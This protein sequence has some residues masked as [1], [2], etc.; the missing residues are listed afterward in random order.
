MNNYNT[1]SVCYQI[2][3]FKL[4]ALPADCFRPADIS[5]N[6]LFR[7]LYKPICINNKK[8]TWSTKWRTS[9][10]SVCGVNF[11]QY[12][13]CNNGWCDGKQRCLACCA[14]YGGRLS[15][16]GQPYQLEFRM[17]GDGQLV[18]SCWFWKHHLNNTCWEWYSGRIR[19]SWKGDQFHLF[20]KEKKGGWIIK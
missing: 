17:L 12:M 13:C 18:H 2:L 4:N 5:C 20:L 6:R 8:H 19:V 7:Q 14:A 3:K 9:N 11:I 16:V 15:W 1:R 10:T